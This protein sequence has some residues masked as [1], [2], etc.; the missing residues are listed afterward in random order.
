MLAK[1]LKELI[2]FVAQLRLSR[3]YQQLKFYRGQNNNYT[4]IILYKQN[5]KNYL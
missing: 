4:I 3:V 2:K 5:N 1:Y